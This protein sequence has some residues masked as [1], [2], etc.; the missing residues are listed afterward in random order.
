MDPV[1][2]ET[3][4]NVKPFRLQPWGYHAVQGW[5]F[6]TDL[7]HYCVIKTVTDTGYFRLTDT[8][9]F[10][11]YA[12]KNSTVNPAERIVKETQSLVLTIQAKNDAPPD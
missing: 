7:K 3:I 10:K 4:I 2:T 5:Y 6:A 11:H 12:I 8:F 9:K 1:G